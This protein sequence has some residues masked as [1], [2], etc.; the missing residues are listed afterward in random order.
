VIGEA[1]QELVSKW[2]VYDNRTYSKA[3]FSFVNVLDNPNNPFAVA[4]M[5]PLPFPF[6]FDSPDFSV[7]VYTDTTND[8][9]KLTSP[10]YTEPFTRFRYKFVF[11]QS[12][13][14]KLKDSE[15]KRRTV[16]II[17]FS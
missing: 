2:I 10:E 1:G 12:G 9:V 11:I 16:F 5:F 8:W 3:T 15:T 13:Q 17:T 14:I 7:Y 6:N 4:T